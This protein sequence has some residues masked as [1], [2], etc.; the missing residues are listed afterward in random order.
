M[1]DHTRSIDA[2]RL[3]EMLTNEVEDSGQ[4]IST[5][6]CGLELV[7]ESAS[8]VELFRRLHDAAR[9]DAA[10]LISGEVGDGKA[11]AAAIIHARSRR[12]DSRFVAVD[13]AAL[14]ETLHEATIF[15]YVKGAFTIGIKHD[16]ARCDVAD[17]GTLYL[18]HVDALSSDLQAKLLRLVEHC[19]YTPLGSGA[20]L[21]SNVRL[22]AST[23][24]DLDGV[25]QRGTF[26]EAL[27]RRFQSVVVCVPPL[28][29]RGDDVLRIAQLLVSR[30]QGPLDRR[31]M[32][33]SVE[34]ARAL[35]ACH[36]PGN[37]RE[38]RC[39]IERAMITSKD[40]RT[41]NLQSIE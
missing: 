34:D 13:C 24:C 4:E 17:G 22:V 5:I 18:A 41:L 12:R 27:H 7:G 15:G 29:E 16:A 31:E 2:E 14:P 1:A 10:V 23:T 32:R 21:R 26:N 40:G 39:V 28:R 11:S 9:L 37:V 35:R 19:E 6:R 8:L 30:L 20:V 33:T 25:V 3:A 38:L 36:W